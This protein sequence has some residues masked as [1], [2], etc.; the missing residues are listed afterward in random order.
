MLVEHA[1]GVILHDRALPVL[2]L[3][4]DQFMQAAAVQEIVLIHKPADAFQFV[5]GG[6]ELSS[7][8]SMKAS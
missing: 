5:E 8:I 2:T 3:V 6:G 4:R 1:A 7:S